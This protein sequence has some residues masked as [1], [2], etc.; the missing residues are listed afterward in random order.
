MIKFLIPKEEKYFDH[1]NDMIDNTFEMATL[2][3]ELFS[4]SKLNFEVQ[5]R[6]FSL[7]RRCDEV[8]DKILKRLNK[9]FITP[10]DREDIVNLSHRIESTSD[11]L[12]ALASRLEILNLERKI[13]GA[14]KLTDI[15]YLQVK[16][17]HEAIHELKHRNNTTNLCKAV[18]D[19]ESE[20]DTVYKESMKNLFANETDPIVLI[21]NKEILDMLEKTVD[22]LQLVANAILTIYVKNS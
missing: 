2:I 8:S 13:E 19:L 11:S 21:K 17:L 7:E 14:Q 16:N 20:A 6:I 9:T 4:N 3:K 18:Q 15:I 12:K 10:F 5:Q 22:K 1:F